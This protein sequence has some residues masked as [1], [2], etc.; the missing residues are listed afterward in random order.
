MLLN[1]MC[2]HVV[3]VVANVLDIG[4]PIFLEHPVPSVGE[5]VNLKFLHCRLHTTGG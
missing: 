2:T 1:D 3:V 5:V 4:R